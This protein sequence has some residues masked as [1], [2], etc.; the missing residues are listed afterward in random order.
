MAESRWWF[1]SANLDRFFLGG[2][3]GAVCQSEEWHN[4]ELVMAIPSSE[5]RP[6]NVLLS[7]SKLESS[8]NCSDNFFI[9]D[10]TNRYGAR[11][12][13]V[14]LGIKWIWN[15]T[16]RAGGSPGKSS[17]NTS[18]KSHMIGDISLDMPGV[19]TS[20][21]HFPW[22]LPHCPLSISNFGITDL[23]QCKVPIRFHCTCH[24]IGRPWRH[25]ALEGLLWLTMVRSRCISTSFL[26]VQ[27][28]L[29]A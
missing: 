11:A 19:H 28:C 8:Y 21:Q 13:G 23:L 17:G 16:G 12:T 29:S 6:W 18:G 24:H 27:N 14:A 5:C 2:S 26:F 9:S 7:Y 1:R 4:L 3:Q 10:G 25:S 22:E 15:S 20:K